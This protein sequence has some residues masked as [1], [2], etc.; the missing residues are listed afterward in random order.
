MNSLMSS[1]MAGTECTL[2]TAVHSDV[3]GAATTSAK[4]SG[5]YHIKSRQDLC[6]LVL[7]FKADM[8]RSTLLSACSE[9]TG[10]GGDLMMSKSLVYALGYHGL[11]IPPP[12]TSLP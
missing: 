9:E 5:E 3:V 4:C 12:L 1:H 11:Q 10:G 6:P 8:H 7:K 2:S